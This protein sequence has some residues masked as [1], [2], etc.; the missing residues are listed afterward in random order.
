MTQYLHQDHP[1]LSNSTPTRARVINEILNLALCHS[2]SFRVE[3]DRER[4]EALL[5]AASFKKLLP[6]RPLIEGSAS[7]YSIYESEL[8]DERIALL[9]RMLSLETTYFQESPISYIES[10]RFMDRD[11]RTLLRMSDALASILLSLP[12]PERETLAQAWTEIGTPREVLETIELDLEA[13]R[14]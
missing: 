6:N 11:G 14:P 4:L 10:I 1:F 9:R 2:R 3:I 13:L 8:D 7:T 12:E 5:G